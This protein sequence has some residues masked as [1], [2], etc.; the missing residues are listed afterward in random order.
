MVVINETHHLSAS[1]YDLQ[2]YN[3]TLRA[4]AFIHACGQWEQFVDKVYSA[5]PALIFLED[6]KTDRVSSDVIPEES[7][8]L[9]DYQARERA[10]AIAFGNTITNINSSKRPQNQT[11]LKTFNYKKRELFWRDKYNE[12]YKL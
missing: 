7:I 3:Q 4:F 2:N 5:C 12:F 6:T 10:A 9:Y 1:D 8:Q 11:V